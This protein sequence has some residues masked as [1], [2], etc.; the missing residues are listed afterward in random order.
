MKALAFTVAASADLNGIW[1]YTEAEWSLAQARKYTTEIRDV[2]R[3]L[4]Q[5][6]KRGRATSVRLG[7]LKYLCGSH[8]IYFR[9]LGDTLEIVRILHRA[10]DAE[11]NLNE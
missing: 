10:Q 6:Q 8:V 5:G 7:Y 2:C 11:R 3:A 4:A 9:D 1:D